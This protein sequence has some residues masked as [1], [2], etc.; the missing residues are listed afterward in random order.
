VATAT[1]VTSGFIS[2]ADAHRRLLKRP[3]L[4]Y[5]VV[6]HPIVSMSDEELLA[7]ADAIFDEVAGVIARREEVPKPSN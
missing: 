4:P 1:V 5:F 2:A 6:P 3:D 7:S